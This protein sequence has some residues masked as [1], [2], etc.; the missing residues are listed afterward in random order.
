MS[1]RIARIFIAALCVTA[2][3]LHAQTL[4]NFESLNDGDLVTTQFT[5]VTFSNAQT[6]TAGFSLDDLEYPAHSGKNVITDNSGP[7][8]LIFSSPISA[9]SGYFTHSK[10]I[11]V[12]AFNGGG[13]QVAVTSSSHDNAAVSGDGTPPNEL[14]SLSATSIAKVVITGNATGNSVV[15]DDLSYQIALRPQTITFGKPSGQTLGVAPFVLTATASSGLTVAFASN[16]T[17]VCTVSGIDVTLLT[18]GTCSITASQ[19]G[20]SIYA[21]ATSVTQTFTV[22][23]KAQTITFGKPSGQTLGVA[24]FAL[25]ATA[26]SGLAVTFTSNSPLVCT[27]SLVT[28]TLLTDGTCSIT[29]SQAGNSTYAPATF[30]TQTFTVTGKAQTITFGKPS[31]QTLGVAPFALT[32]TASS[33]LG[34]TFTSNSPTVC[35]VS[36]VTVTLLTDGTCSITASQSGNSIYAPATSVTQAFTITGK[37]QTITFAKPSPEV[38]GVAPFALTATVSSGLAVTFASN[39]LTVCT[40]SGV[41]ATLLTDGTCSITASQ[42]GNSTW[43][44]AI[45]V[46]QAFLVA[47]KPQTLTFGTLGGQTLG[48]APFALTATASSGLAVTFTSNSP[49]VCTVSGADV[50]LLTG[51]TCSITASQAGNSI[52]AAATSVT[53]TFTV[54]KPQTITFGPLSNQPLNGSAPPALSATATSGLAVVFTSNSPKVCTVFEVY[55]TLRSA[56]TCSIT[57]SQSGNAIYA[58]AAAVTQTFMVVASVAAVPERN[59]VRVLA[60][61]GPMN[62]PYAGGFPIWT[63][64]AAVSPTALAG[65]K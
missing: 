15:A 27:V 25:T 44:P 19:A 10:A 51:G 35:T 22:T 28:V 55:I 65:R 58:A 32:A 38:L 21:A 29:A 14:L 18:D 7:I 63:P 33:G 8:A 54:L 30:V 6:L 47:G 4:L 41:T 52:Y 60:F 16:S 53:Q 42:A 64:G 59:G 46:T 23:G 20:D 5:G 62:F 57:A 49:M 17:A 39:S 36:L 9:F 43:A 34:V 48:V 3:T 12:A 61:N 56:G 26:S 45:S 1:S 31:G 40:V 50:T 13:T 24:P 37:P 11:T 2:P